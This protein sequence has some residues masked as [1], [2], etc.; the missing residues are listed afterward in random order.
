VVN[1]LRQVTSA[2]KQEGA[3]QVSIITSAAD[4]EAATQLGIAAAMR[5]QIVGQALDVISRD[6]EIAET[7]FQILENQKMLEGGGEITLIPQNA[8]LLAQLLTA[9][10][11]APRPVA[12]EP[13][14][15]KV[16]RP[17]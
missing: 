3:N 7:M 15:P 1:R 10:T 11:Q 16:D 6:Q 17:K 13:K 5:P 4:R 12:S 8:P 9:R 2:I 14:A